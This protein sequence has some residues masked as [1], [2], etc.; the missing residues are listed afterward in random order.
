MQLIIQIFENQEAA[1]VVENCVFVLGVVVDGGLVFAG[2]ADRMHKLQHLPNFLLLILLLLARA[3]NA[4]T[5]LL[6]VIVCL[7]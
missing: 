5:H 4:I 2:E 6:L 1:A 3:A 7:V